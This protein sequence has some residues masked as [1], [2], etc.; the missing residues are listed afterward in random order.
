M[1]VRA[2]RHLFLYTHVESYDFIRKCF[3]PFVYIDTH[4][5]KICCYIYKCIYFIIFCF[6]FVK[7]DVFIAISVCWWIYF[8]LS[9]EFWV[10][11]VF[12]KFLYTF[13][14]IKRKFLKLFLNITFVFLIWCEFIWVWCV[15]Y[16]LM[17]FVP[18]SEISINTYFFFYT[19]NVFVWAACWNKTQSPVNCV[20][21][22]ILKHMWIY[23]CIYVYEFIDYK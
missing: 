2:C 22:Y 18:R 10:F 5:S 16:L 13:N 9:D 11:R 8:I 3:E 17:S 4:M 20:Y 21:T 14:H 7:T 15:C 1:Y 19:G 23:G 12:H 6:L